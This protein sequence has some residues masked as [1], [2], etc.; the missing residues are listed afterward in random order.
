MLQASGQKHE[1]PPHEERNQHRQTETQQQKQ[2][3]HDDFVE[4]AEE[5]VAATGSKGD[6]G[7]QGPLQRMLHEL[8][9]RQP[10]VSLLTE[11]LKYLDSHGWLIQQQPLPAA[12]AAA[13]YRAAAPSILPLFVQ[14]QRL[15]V[16]RQQLQAFRQ[17]LPLLL[18][19]LQI[20]ES[21]S[22]SLAAATSRLSMERQNLLPLL[23]ELL[24]LRQQRQHVEDTEFVCQ[25]ILKR[26]LLFQSTIKSMT[27]TMPPASAAEATA[28]EL[29]DTMHA[30]HLV[31]E[32]RQQLQAAAAATDAG[33]LLIEDLLLQMQELQDV[34]YERLF[35]LVLQRLQQLAA[36]ATA[37]RGSV[38]DNRDPIATSVQALHKVTKRLQKGTEQQQHM[39]PPAAY[40]VTQADAAEAE[41]S[42][43]DAALWEA[44]ADLY[45]HPAYVLQCLQQLLRLRRQLLV[46]RF[47][48]ATWGPLEI[49]NA[50][51][52]QSPFELALEWVAGAAA[53][54]AD[55]FMC[56]SRL[57]PSFESLEV[58][59][60]QQQEHPQQRPVT[61]PTQ[62]VAGQ[63]SSHEGVPASHDSELEL[64]GIA[65]E[66]FQMS[67]DPQRAPEEQLQ[68]QQQY[69]SKELSSPHR[70][71]HQQEQELRHEW[72]PL[73][74]VPILPWKGGG[75]GATVLQ[76][77]S[78]LPLIDAALEVLE[79]PLAARLSKLLSS[80]P[81]SSN[82]NCGILALKAAFSLLR[83]A[84]RIEQIFAAVAA[85]SSPQKS[86]QQQD[87]QLQRKAMLSKFLL[88]LAEKALA[89]FEDQWEAAALHLPQL[90]AATAAKWS[91][92]AGAWEPRTSS[93]PSFLTH[94]AARLQDLLLALATCLPPEQ[95][96]TQ[97]QEEQQQR[98]E[99]DQKQQCD[100]EISSLQR[101]DALLGR[102]V[103]RAANYCL[104][105]A[106]HMEDP[107]ACVFIINALCCLR[108]ALQPLLAA[109]PQPHPQQQLLQQIVGLRELQ[110]Q[111][112]LLSQ[113]IEDKTA[114]LGILEGNRLCDCF[115]VTLR[116]EAIEVYMGAERSK[117]FQVSE[118]LRNKD[119]AASSV[120][121]RKAAEEV[122]TQEKL[123][124]FFAFF[125]GK[126]YGASAL[127][128]P[129]LR[130]LSQAGPRREARTKALEALVGGFAAI[131]T[132]AAENGRALSP[133]TP[134]QTIPTY[135]MWTFHTRLL[136]ARM[137]P[138]KVCM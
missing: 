9:L 100:E 6:G 111:H 90:S 79:G 69:L 46:Q 92:T 98:E 70:Q 121:S 36:A 64:E 61:T 12:A 51:E 35:L 40:S 47:M 110:Q 57:F 73:S 67:R 133:H 24:H 65:A 59:G 87:E 76:L 105:A 38:R 96:Q 122:L 50:A 29:R 129:L 11:S 41:V 8:Q 135:C 89:A 136:H 113:L 112:R 130:S 137:A 34:G 91:P 17:I 132:F 94:F 56:L 117:A 63:F 43:D 66:D 25:T 33:C 124:D 138:L 106:H 22:S 126:V 123:E 80:D 4:V 125:M 84:A 1:K 18:L 99:E 27:R 86:E 14:R 97:G 114:E 31:Q 49:A 82:S 13:R 120:M 81:H 62:I 102:D 118:H 68:Q 104:Q 21:L 32:K 10:D 39:T 54:E 103:L 3:Q 77:L 2:Q 20:A 128:L 71:K 28:T 116:L 109:F 37:T 101:L 44:L 19:L 78:P 134:E 15:E 72:L 7:L 58:L 74:E 119:A 127:D 60:V 55:F 107:H 131:S 83:V 45:R 48:A 108:S 52:V 16:Y 42:A 53:E 26:F 75:G 95:Q 5:A 85:Q 30:L 93:L 88:E 115:G 23:Q